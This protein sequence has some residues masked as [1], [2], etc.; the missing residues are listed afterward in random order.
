MMRFRPGTPI[1]RDGAA[2]RGAAG[3]RRPATAGRPAA[4][5]PPTRSTYP[6]SRAT[7][8]GRPRPRSVDRVGRV[9]PERRR[10]DRARGA[11]RRVRPS[12]WCGHAGGPAD[13]VVLLVPLL[14]TGHRRRRAGEPARLRRAR[15]E[16][17][18]GADR[19]RLEL[20]VSAKGWPWPTAS[21]RS[22]DCSATVRASGRRAGI[23]LAPF[24]VGARSTLATEHPD[25]LVGPAGRNWGESSSAST[26]PIAASSTC[27]PR[28][29]RGWST[30]A[31]TTSSSTSSTPEPCRADGHDGRG[32]GQAYRSGLSLIREVVGPEVYLV[33]CG[34]PLLPSVGLVDAMRV[35][36]RHL[37]R[38]R[39]GRFA[40]PA[41]ADAAGRAGLAAG[42]LLGQRPRLR[43]RPAD[44]R[45]AG[46]VGR[47]GDR[48]FGGL[49][50][51]SDRVADLDEQ[52]LRC[53]RDLLASGGTAAPVAAEPGARGRPSW[54]RRRGR[55]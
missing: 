4:T 54:P 20:R 11:R 53:V 23:W 43:R 16:R 31:S 51:F 2:G 7:L 34:A 1:A 45:P 50:S 29:S 24:V 6:P 27:S 19:R 26:S 36:S 32:R 39:R 47:R 28:R 5:A 21:A 25:W 12:G 14:R 22:K 38:G 40:R 30:S 9:D 44:L 35:V 48:R 13:S 33:G 52:G 15:P 10:R 3:G 41:R 37:P 55:R 17:R 49:A 42:P 46:A 18:C 8:V